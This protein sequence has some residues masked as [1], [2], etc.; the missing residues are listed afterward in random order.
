LPFRERK[1]KKKKKN[2]GGVAADQK[3]NRVRR[4]GG[5]KKGPFLERKKIGRK[6][7]GIK[8]PKKGVFNYL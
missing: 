4:R 1:D 5:R 7:K 3:K 2:W 8:L 6:G